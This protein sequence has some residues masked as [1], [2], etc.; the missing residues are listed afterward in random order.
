VGSAD[1]NIRCMFCAVQ[2][3]GVM[4]RTRLH[5]DVRGRNL[6]SETFPHLARNSVRIRCSY[7]GCF[8]TMSRLWRRHFAFGERHPAHESLNAGRGVL[9][10]YCRR[11]TEPN[12]ADSVQYYIRCNARWAR[13]SYDCTV[14]AGQGRFGTISYCQAL[15]KYYRLM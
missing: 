2:S 10:L 6:G 15:W 7:F 1:F 9:F 11:M 4:H 8:K 3:L 14:L 5:R 12:T 13:A